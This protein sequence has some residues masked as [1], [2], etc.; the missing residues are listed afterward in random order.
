[1]AEA[2]G[3]QRYMPVLTAQ[4]LEG[5]FGAG[6]NGLLPGATGSVQLDLQPGSYVAFCQVPASRSLPTAAGLIKPVTVKAPAAEPKGSALPSGP[7]ITLTDKAIEVP[8]GF[9]GEGL[10]RVENTGDFPHELL[11]YRVAED[12]TYD[13]AVEWLTA[14][15]PPKGPA[16]ATL[17]GGVTALSGDQ[18]AAVDLDLAGG[19]YIFTSFLSGADGKGDETNGLIEQVIIP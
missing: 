12:T 6:P 11:V 10:F 18:E 3:P 8:T 14:K 9:S 7:T 16:K 4:A 15:V 5:A 2:A 1:M 19:I 13:D 17:A